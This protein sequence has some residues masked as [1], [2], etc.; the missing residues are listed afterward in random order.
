MEESLMHQL[1]VDES[2][3]LIT[4]G[5]KGMDYL[6]RFGRPQGEKRPKHS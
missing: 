6:P 3:D 5:I 4:V 2:D 1:V